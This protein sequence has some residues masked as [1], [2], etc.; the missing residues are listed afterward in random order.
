LAAKRSDDSTFAEQVRA[1]RE[2]P[3]ERNQTE[4]TLAMLTE[5]ADRREGFALACLRSFDELV[6]LFG[7]RAASIEQ[8]ARQREREAAEGA[9]HAVEAL[10]AALAPLREARAVLA[11]VASAGRR[12]PDRAFAF[13][14]DG[15]LHV[16]PPS[17]SSPTVM[18]DGT[19]RRG[20]ARLSSMTAVIAAA[21]GEV[22]EPAEAE[23][24]ETAGAPRLVTDPAGLAKS[25]RAG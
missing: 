16:V 14:G 12:E 5:Q 17:A 11:W 7:Q 8:A 13:T 24:A 4:R 3:T 25:Q 21:L 20:T 2:P 23:P 6:E 19:R 1:G 10:A 9:L 22:A 18:L 15:E